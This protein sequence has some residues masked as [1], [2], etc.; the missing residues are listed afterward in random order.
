MSYSY[1][2]NLKRNRKNKMLN[3]YENVVLKNKKITDDI[4]NDRL[5]NIRIIEENQKKMQEEIIKTRQ[6]LAESIKQKKQKP[7][8]GDNHIIQNNN[9]V[10]LSTGFLTTEN[11]DD[12]II[13]NRKN[14]KNLNLK[15]QQNLFKLYYMYIKVDDEVQGDQIDEEID[16]E[17]DVELDTEEI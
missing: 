15:E 4:E 9:I 13:E 11:K 5:Y 16:E 12:Y 7:D 17:T 10:S 8:G 3:Y 14:F 1:L 6:F 2:E